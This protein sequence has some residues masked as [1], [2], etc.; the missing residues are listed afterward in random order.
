M[1]INFSHFIDS[2]ANAKKALAALI[3]LCKAFDVDDRDIHAIIR[4]IAG[5]QNAEI[6]VIAVYELGN[7]IPTMKKI[8]VIKLIRMQTGC[9]LREAKIAAESM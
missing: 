1:E 5:T 6:P 2:R 8:Q 3:H 7:T 9:G 4:S